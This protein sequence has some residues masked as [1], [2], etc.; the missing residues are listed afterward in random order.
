MAEVTVK[1]EAP[2]VTRQ[3]FDP[4]RPS[5]KMPK[6]TP[7]ESGVCD[8]D[9]VIDT[10]VSYSI[11]AAT[12]DSLEI[13]VDELD[14]VTSLEVRIWT[15][16][17][18]P[19]KLLAHEEGHR[20]ICEYYYQ[21]A[22]IVAR[23]VAE[24][25]IGRTYVGKGPNRKAAES[26]AVKQIT[27][28]I[29]DAY[30]ARTRMRCS[31][32][33][34]RY[35][36]LTKHGLTP[37]PEAEAIATILKV[38]P[39]PSREALLAQLAAAA[40]APAAAT[41]AAPVQEFWKWPDLVNRPERWPLATHLLRPVTFQDGTKFAKGTVLRVT[42]VTPREVEVILP[43]G[44]P[45][46]FGPGE[47][48]LVQAAN[49]YWAA[50]TP[51]QRA[52]DLGAIVKD[53]TLLPPS[54]MTHVQLSFAKGPKP[55]GSEVPTVDIVNNRLHV[56]S[57]A[58]GQAMALAPMETD[59]LARARALA[60]LPPEK[61]VKAAWTT[62]Y[63]AALARAKEENRKVFL[64]FTG[65]DW[66]GWCMRLEREILRMPEFTDYAA[67]KLV[68]VKL[69]FP[70]GF[71]LPAAVAAQNQKLAEQYGVRGYPTVVV[72]DH[73]GRAVGQLGYQEGGASPFLAR[74]EAF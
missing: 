60:A 21:N 42:K 27:T 5:P 28:A 62:D 53:R 45:T 65:S 51:D 49:L 17:G 40:P 41:P 11:G 56:W 2:K 70:R 38:D 59:L 35:D 29:S 26:D 9:F 31:A 7:P 74:L 37:L 19:P 4:K 55:A 20:E 33:Q 43:D 44:S 73:S 22:D 48:D 50:L 58:D 1:R 39:E 61:R 24:P 34:K 6:L 46:T 3:V 63:T 72:L 15:A 30:M 12:A 64:F 52:V 16:Q 71:K 13:T 69:D 36:A 57:A 18:T 67:D 32:A 10:G 47:T 23:A 54:V 66:C 8:F 68:L 14:L 25:L